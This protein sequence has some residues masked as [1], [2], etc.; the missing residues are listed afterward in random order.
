MKIDILTEN[1]GIM[2]YNNYNRKLIFTNE[3]LSDIK[4]IKQLDNITKTNSYKK[5]KLHIHSKEYLEQI[6]KVLGLDDIKIYYPPKSSLKKHKEELYTIFGQYIVDLKDMCYVDCLFETQEIK[7]EFLLLLNKNNIT[8]SKVVNNSTHIPNRDDSLTGKEIKWLQDFKKTQYPIYVISKG[9]Y[10]HN[11]TAKFLIKSNIDFKLVIESDEY[12]LYKQNIDEKYLLKVQNYSKRNCGGIPVRNFCFRDSVK[13]GF[14]AHWVLDDNIYGYEL[15]YKSK[16]LR[17]YN[18]CIFTMVEDYF[19]LHKNIGMIGY[20]YSMFC[21]AC[22]NPHPIIKNCHLYSS[23]LINND[24][25]TDCKTINKYPKIKNGKKV[26]IIERGIWRGK[27]NEDVDL[28]IRCIKNGWNVI[29]TNTIVSGKATTKTQKGG[30][31]DTIYKDDDYSYHK[32]MSLVN[33]HPLYVECVKKYNRF[34]HKVDWIKL[35]KD[36]PNELKLKDEYKNK[37]LTNMNDYKFIIE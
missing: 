28:N 13:N 3:D 19:N 30:N 21:I 2:I 25:F 23:M 11:N 10:E 36:Y 5:L 7:D 20:N 12:D 24:I 29:S 9:R 27:Y 4:T 16:K 34:H 26:K 33:Q 17:C 14:K 1:L 18:P 35:Q 32:T 6:K 31:S 22:N 8:F 15:I 37:D